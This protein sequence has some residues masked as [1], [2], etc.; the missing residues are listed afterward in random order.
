M[1]AAL[2]PMSDCTVTIEEIAPIACSTRTSASSGTTS[3][4]PTMAPMRRCSSRTRTTRRRVGVSRETTTS[5]LLS[6]IGG[7]SE[8]V[9]CSRAALTS[10]SGSPGS[11][12]TRV[13]GASNQNSSGWPISTASVLPMSNS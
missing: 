12:S 5:P 9:T 8:I 3:A 13:P 10:S 11:S 4:S 6:L 1:S 2:A 7:R